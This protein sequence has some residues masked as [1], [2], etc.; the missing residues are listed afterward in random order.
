[1]GTYGPRRGELGAVGGVSAI[2]LK[3][4]PDL[5]TPVLDNM[6]AVAGGMTRGNCDDPWDGERGSLGA[7]TAGDDDVPFERGDLKTGT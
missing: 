7:V 2:G 5:A 3:N 4:P 6:A 1:M